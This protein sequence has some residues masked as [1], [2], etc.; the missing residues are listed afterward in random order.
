MLYKTN[1]LPLLC[2]EPADMSAEILR[3]MEVVCE[4]NRPN[5]EGYLVMLKDALRCSWI[6][7]YLV[8]T[9]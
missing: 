4:I 3:T 9:K 6:L 1:L 2:F 5:G 8:Q 7:T